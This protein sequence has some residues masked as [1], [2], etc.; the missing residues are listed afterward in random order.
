MYTYYTLRV[1]VFKIFFGFKT[2][3]V[4]LLNCN[5]FLLLILGNENKSSKAVGNGCDLSADKSN[6]IWRF[7]QLIYCVDKKWVPKRQISLF[8]FLNNKRLIFFWI[9]GSGVEC[10]RRD[11]VIQ[12]AFMMYVSYFVLFANFF[13]YS[14]IKSSPKALKK[15][16]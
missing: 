7:H 11:E 13:Y 1:S 4:L 8:I 10:V 14:Y 9:Q 3:L 5:G 12:L 16:E 2:S 15:K 6:D